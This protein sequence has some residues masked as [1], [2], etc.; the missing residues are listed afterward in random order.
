MKTSTPGILL[1]SRCSA[2]PRGRPWGSRSTSSFPTIALKKNATS[3]AGFM[4]VRKSTITNTVRQRKD[5]SRIHVS[6]VASPVRTT[7]GTIIG[8]SKVARDISA[9]KEIEAKLTLQSALVELSDEAIFA[10]DL[11]DGIVEGNTG[12]ERLYVSNAVKFTAKHGVVQVLLERVNSHV[13]IVVSD[14]GT[15]IA[16]EFLPHIFERFRQADGGTTREH[17][18]LG[19]GPPIRARR[20]TRPPAHVKIPEWSIPV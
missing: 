3:S 5:G 8:V 19:L 4:R 7:A 15:G 18:G 12:C 14:T 20:Q 9:Q 6:M 16:A 10:W 13:E 1:L 2:T 17:G 11:H